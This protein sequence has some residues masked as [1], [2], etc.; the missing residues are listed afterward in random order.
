VINPNIGTS[1]IEDNA[2]PPGAITGHCVAAVMPTQMEGQICTVQGIRFPVTS[3]CGNSHIFV[4]YDYDSN[5]MHTQAMPSKS[6]AKI[7]K[8]YKSVHNKLVFVGLSTQPQHLNNRCS[9]I[10]H[11][12]LVEQDKRFNWYH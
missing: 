6:A 12:Y 5:S 9:A 11:E 7:L 4:L 10:L 1:D 2:P 3:S 8:F